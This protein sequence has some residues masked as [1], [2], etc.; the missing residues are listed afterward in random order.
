MSASL[1][2]IAWY[3]MIGLP[4]TISR[5]GEFERRLERAAR[6]AE[7]V[8]RY[9][10]AVLRQRIQHDAVGPDFAAE[11]AV[12][13]NERILD[14]D[15]SGFGERIPSFFSLLISKP[16]FGSSTMNRLMASVECSGLVR[17]ATIRKSA[18]GALVM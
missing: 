7:T 10:D 12:V 4:R 14:V 18:I 3:S 11:Q 8:G 5:L 13:G 1:W 15:Q 16:G 2:A 6:H 9:A 17:A